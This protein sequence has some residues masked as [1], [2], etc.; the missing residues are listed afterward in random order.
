MSKSIDRRVRVQAQD[1]QR[2]GV[3]EAEPTVKIRNVLAPG[4]VSCRICS[5]YKGKK[6]RVIEIRRGGSDSCVYFCLPCSER[7]GLAAVEPS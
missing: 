1:Q 2:A 6:A 4:L 5:K 3:A 7:V